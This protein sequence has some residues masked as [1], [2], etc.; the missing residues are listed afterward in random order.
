[1]ANFNKVFLMGNLTRDPEL[2]YTQG[3]TAVAEFGM[4]INRQ[5]TTPDGETKEEVCYVDVNA[6]GRQAEIICEYCSKGRPLFVEGRL[7]Y[8]TWVGQDGQKRNKLR[9]IVENFQ[10]IG[11][12]VRGDS[13]GAPVPPPAEESVAQQAP[14][15]IPQEPPKPTPQS[16]K[17]KKDDE[18]P[19]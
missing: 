12:Q 4:A 9:V 7:Q 2:R 18:I 5:W 16:G 3:G 19:F 11:G 8:H 13:K 10:F 6:W 17:P 14:P 1:M 15:S